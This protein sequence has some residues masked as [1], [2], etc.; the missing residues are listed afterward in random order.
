MFPAWLVIAVVGVAIASASSLLS[1]RDI[2]WFKRQRRP[3]WLTF[4]FAIPVV[5]TVVFICGGWS[6]YIVWRQTQSW[7]FMA[8]YIL[9]EL[10]IVSYTPVMCKLQNLRVGTAIG[11]AGFVFGLLLAWQVAQIDTTAFFLLLPYLLWSP[12]G[13]LITWQMEQL[14]P[15]Q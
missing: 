15:G 2:K 9:L 7:W 12:V 1:S 6:A 13:T 4:E 14:N 5:W 8:G 11:A 3:D 10:L